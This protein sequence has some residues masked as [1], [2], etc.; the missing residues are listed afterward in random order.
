[1]R[2]QIQTER[3]FRLALAACLVLLVLQPAMTALAGQTVEGVVN[4]NTATE[5]EL[6]QLPRVGASVAKRIIAFRDKNGPFQ[7]AEDL[8]NVQGI[9]EK[10]FSKLLPHMAVAGETTLKKVPEKKASGN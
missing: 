2:F 8:M 1:M 3:I 9:G 4:L 7:R 5:D 6:I 10:T